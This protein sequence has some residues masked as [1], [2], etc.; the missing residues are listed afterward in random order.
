MRNLMGMRSPVVGSPAVGSELGVLRCFS[1]VRLF[2]HWGIVVSE[3]F[4]VAGP[5]VYHTVPC[6]LA[7]VW[8]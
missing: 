7:Q 2:K 8:T 6:Q 3:G 5:H 4:N 1:S